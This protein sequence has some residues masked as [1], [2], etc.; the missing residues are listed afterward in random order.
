MSACRIERVTAI[1]Y[2]LEPHDWTYPLDAEAAI[3][4]HWAALRAA[5]PAL[6]D[7][8]VLVAHRLAITDGV[9]HAAGFETR[10]KPFIAW[11]DA[12][13]PGVPV[14]NL[15]A[16]AALRSAD[17]AF[18]LGAMSAGTT[19][20]GRLYFP[21]GTPEPSD[22]HEGIVDLAGNALREL[23]EETGLGPGDV[24]PE[25]GWTL[26]FEGA[27]VACMRN[28]RST[29]TAEAMLDR[30]AAFNATQAEPELDALVPVRAMGD[31]DP[32]R[33]PGFMIAYLA[34][35]FSLTPP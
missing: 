1:D 27:R 19:S 9:L 5:K 15:F 10:Y 18:M 3:D 14:F 31:V 12:G 33:M 16:M 17:G 11:R 8:R 23:A 4:A 29:L 28:L 30:F 35:A 22:A 24:E 2:R 34:A 6:F 21:A 7:G 20:A 25:P 13:F 32:A 26:V